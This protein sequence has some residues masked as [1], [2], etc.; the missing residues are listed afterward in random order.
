MLFTREG[1]TLHL[2]TTGISW[3]DDAG[4]TWH[5]LGIGGTTYYP[6]SVQLSDGTIFC[7]G[8]RGGDNPYNGSVNQEILALTFRLEV[9]E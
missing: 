8:H 4:E 6:R 1:V 9:Q 5:N 2:A 3:T 7:V